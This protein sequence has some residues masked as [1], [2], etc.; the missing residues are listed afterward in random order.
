MSNFHP[1]LIIGL[2]GMGSKIVEGIY[3]KFEAGNPTD[4]ERANVAF[5][6][7]DTDE[8]DIEDR[9]KVMPPENVVKTSSDLSTTI[10]HYIERI[11]NDTD[12]LKW[13]DTWS[14]ELNS[15]ALNSGAAQ[16]RMASRLAMM[17]AINE[18][19]FAPVDNSIAQLMSTDPARH[20]GNDI[21]IHIISS[22]AGGTGAGTFLQVAYYV[23]NAMKEQGAEAPKTYG[24]FVLADV[25]S[26]DP[27]VGFDKTQKENTSSNTYACMKELVA[28]SSSDKNNGL[29]TFEFEYK[30]GQ[31]DK[32][33]PIDPPYDVCFLIDRN[34]A[35]GG[36]LIKHDRY[37]DQVTSYV[38]LS[39]FSDVGDNYR[40]NAINNVRTLIESDGK[41]KFAS[42][43]VSKLVYPVDDLFA[44][45]AHQRVADNMS[46]TWCQIDKDIQ[47]R[48]DEYKEHVHNGVPDTQ[49]DKGDEFMGHVWN[50]KDGAGG[51]A[52]QFKQIYNSTQVLNEDFTPIM[53]KAKVFVDEVKRFVE[54]TVNRNRDLNGLYETCTAPSNF[55][56]RDDLDNDIW[57]VVRRE[58]ELEDYRKA[59]MA[60]IDSAKQWVIRECFLVD[61]DTEDFVSKMPEANRHHLNSFI[62]EKDNEMHPIAV[63]YFL[64]DIKKRLK[65]ILDGDESLRNSNKELRE[66]IE[67]E[68]KRAFDL[69][70]TPDR[71]E[72]AVDS[73]K[74]ARKKTAGVNKL[75]SLISGQNPYSSA[76]D[77]YDSLSRQQAENIHTYATDKLMEEVYVGLLGQINRLIEESENFFE[78][79]PAALQ[80]LDNERIALLTMHN[81]ANADK[82]VEYVLASE[83]QK[84]DI[85]DFVISR[86]DSPFFPTK[87]S[88]SIYRTMF[89]NT[90]KE[91]NTEGYTTSR[92]KDKKTR[93]AETVEANKNIIRECIAYQNEIIR[94]TNPNY[95]NMNVLD[96]LKEESMRE[97]GNDKDQAWEYMKQKFD[98]FKKRAE[99][100]GPN[101]LDDEVRFINA[102]GLNP[103]CVD[104][105]TISVEKANELF[106]DTNVETNPKTAATRLM[107]EYFSKREIVRANT[108]TLLAIDKYF[109]KFIAKEKT[110]YTEESYGSYYV[111]YQDVILKMRQPDSKTF[112]PHLDKYWH[113]PSYM[114]NIGSSIDEEK[115]KL[116]RALYGGLL[117]EKFKAVHYGGEYYWKYKNNKTFQYIKDIDGRN[118]NIGQSQE[119]A[120]NNLFEK[121][122]VNNP[123]I[124]DQVNEYVEMKWAEAKEDWLGVERD[125]TNELQQM[126]ASNIVKAIIDFRFSIHSSFK[127]DQNWF[128]ILNSRKGLSLYTII[129]EHKDFFFEDLMEH[130][131]EI[132]GQSINTKK[133]CKYVLEKAGAK[134]KDDVEILLENFEE[135][136]FFEPQDD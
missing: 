39:A 61:Y 129:N 44:Y 56:K 2:G 82:S 102:W 10:G 68:Y 111:A 60:F 81:E 64:Y 125:E 43:G 108:A 75:K 94:E 41:K 101:N 122:L 15:M 59:V 27:N 107:S 79:L 63:R 118:I 74:A 105:S 98:H 65:S 37:Y 11:K 127:K 5:L 100:F 131:I 53:P 33:I 88:A 80:S 97:S 113:L 47:K 28:F 110:R 133:L 18:G 69:I 85:Y 76:K 40:R 117:F 114:P 31:R 34:G 55:S 134:M 89:Q 106:G 136:G 58:R 84:K 83:Q 26:G 9:R 86:N 121:G 22:L 87:M 8:D 124:V 132:F 16:V 13:F 71:I 103:D 49:P 57:F 36:N 46:T 95:A 20:Q 116:F 50:Y 73:L 91:L 109:K 70:E 14:Y 66:Q 6:C 78:G 115:K 67:V 32:S 21:K 38:F 120:L 12:V 128:T 29:K 35:D 19:K 3:R 30:K 42:I 24:Y 99:I 23:R 93:R 7:L 25:L 96:A 48:F 77:N 17:S 126:K 135:R 123:G 92:K 1:T 90:C 104:I 45:F 72:T 52:T 119:A 130:L 112:T 62:L 4:R 54:N 51:I